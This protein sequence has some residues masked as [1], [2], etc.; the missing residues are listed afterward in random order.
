VSF[1]SKAP[2]YEAIQWDGSNV[3]ECEAFF[4][5]WFPQPPPP[6]PPGST[7]TPPFAHNADDQTLTVSPG[8]LVNLGDWLVNGGTWPPGSA[9]AG[10]PEVVTDV[11]F[12]SKYVSDGNP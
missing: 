9:W 3:A 8:Y 5:T 10:G 6:W 2:T 4:T 12:Q 1:T 11:V 7:G